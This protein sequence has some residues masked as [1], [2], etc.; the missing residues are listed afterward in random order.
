MNA[1]FEQELSK[2]E[3]FLSE[4]KLQESIEHYSEALNLAST[5]QQKIDLHNVL[6]RLFQKTRNV[7]KSI[8]HFEESLGHYN[9]FPATENLN[10]KAALFNNIGA[11]Y[12]ASD[13]NKAIENSKSAHTI[14]ATLVEKGEK[15]YYPHLANT[16]LALA[17]AY[18]EKNDFFNAKKYF[19]DSIKLY[20]QIPN[21]DSIELKA[22]A[23]YQL[24]N[25]F[26]DEFNLFDA[27]VNYTKSLALLKDLSLK[28]ENAFTPFLAAVLNNLGVTYK[29]MGKHQKSI[30]NYEE[31]L[32]VYQNLVDQNELFLPYVAAT[33]NSL[34]IVYGE[35]GNHEKALEYGRDTITIYND[36]TD[37][38]PGEYT[39]YLAT[40]LH[41]SG[42]FGFELKKFEQAE[43]YF[44][45]AL[46]IRK[47]LALKQPESFDA[48]FCAT[49]LNL[50]ELY[51]VR[52]AGK[53]DMNL[54]I[55]CQDLLNDVNDRLQRQDEDRPVL[56]SMKS[57]CRYYLDYFAEMGTD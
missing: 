43:E 48:D 39:H 24:G 46:A 19:K 25:V 23:Y 45:Q 50:V 33:T 13:I 31:A 36:L 14:Y 9:S 37:A 56:R 26:T 17:E 32:R 4:N 55:K 54:K 52:M 12:L 27:K 47:N 18:L 2:A 40:S 29:S 42:L 21:N 8:L 10:E 1:S 28:D 20:D 57:D 15:S 35:L 11:A 51:Q 34:S 22:R 53:I 41:N 7:K 16:E 6:G 3:I 38:S 5:V 44:E 49:A 30:D